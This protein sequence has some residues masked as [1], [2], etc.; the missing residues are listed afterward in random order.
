MTDD[1]KKAMF[2]DHHDA[3]PSSGGDGDVA[4]AGP[5]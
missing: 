3:A 5:H 4:N 1:G 2:K